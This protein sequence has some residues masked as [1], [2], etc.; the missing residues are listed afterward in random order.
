VIDYAIVLVL[1]PKQNGIDQITTALKRYHPVT[2]LHVIAHGTPGCLYLGNTELSLDTVADYAD[3]LQL[4]LPFPNS[5]LVLYG[6]RV[7]AGD[8]GSEFMERLH[9]LTGAAIAASTT[10]VG[11]SSLN[12]NWHLDVT[13]PHNQTVALCFQDQ[14]LQTDSGISNAGGNVLNVC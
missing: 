10:P 6:C 2:S 5:T 7:A 13:T 11:S 8:A 3:S 1:A 9:Q 12:G 4:W 14:V